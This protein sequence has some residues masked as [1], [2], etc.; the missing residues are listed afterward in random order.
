M[1]L[2]MTGG[3]TVAAAT[4]KV[5]ESEPAPPALAALNTAVKLPA[6]V[7]VPVTS[8]VAA[9]STSPAGKP[10]AVYEVGALLATTW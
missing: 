9:L 10:L 2:V 1:A 7:G 3:A 4:V 8:P 6:T 5:T